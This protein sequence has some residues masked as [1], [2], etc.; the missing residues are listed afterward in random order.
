MLDRLPVELV[1]L[2]IRQAAPLNYDTQMYKARRKLLKSCCLVNRTLRQVAQPMLTEVVEVDG[3]PTASHAYPLG[4][5]GQVRLL[6]IVKRDAEMVVQACANLV[7]LRLVKVAEEFD[8]GLL[9]GSPHLKRLLLERSPFF[10]PDDLVLQSLV[11]LSF[12]GDIY[13]SF[14]ETYTDLNSL[15]HP[16]QVP[17]LRALAIAL[18]TGDSWADDYKLPVFR[19]SL[20]KQLEM[21]SI[22]LGDITVERLTSLHPAPTLC[23]IYWAELEH[24]CAVPHLPPFLHI[25]DLDHLGGAEDREEDLDWAIEALRNVRHFTSH[26]EDLSRLSPPRRDLRL[27]VLSAALRPDEP[28]QYHLIRR[29]ILALLKVCQTLEV[30][31]LWNHEPYEHGSSMVS[32]AL[33][34]WI[35][36]NGRKGTAKWS[37]IESV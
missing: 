35:R 18:C 34:R 8:L 4:M 10:C 20:L 5:A 25:Y 7:D 26:L 12:R 13:W 27:L 32:S 37:V 33:W 9:A 31:V 17:S 23:N 1:E 36:K 28:K 2:I 30:E 6:A 16:S 21:L 3:L 24:L 29:M 15:L 22:D 19:P 11:E 14:Y